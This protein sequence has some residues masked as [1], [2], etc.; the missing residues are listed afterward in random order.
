MGAADAA[1]QSAAAAR[2]FSNAIASGIAETRSQATFEAA[3]RQYSALPSR[4]NGGR[5]NWLPLSNYPPALQGLISGLSVGE[6]TAPIQIHDAAASWI[7]YLKASGAPVSLAELVEAVSPDVKAVFERFVMPGAPLTVPEAAYAAARD[8]HRPALQRL[9]ADYFAQQGV[10]AMLF[11]ATMTAAT[12]IG[13]DET[14]M[15][16]GVAIPFQTAMARNISPG[17]TVGLP[18]LVLPTGLTRDTGLPLAL[19]LDEPAGQDRSLLSLGLALRALMPPMPAP[20]LAERP[21]SLA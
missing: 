18:G 7:A 10:A 14:V 2:I 17:S 3:A 15:I 8:V 11:P 4:N 9:F 16:G 12:L 1:Q 19:E 6:V 5:L 21:T 13:E 20:D